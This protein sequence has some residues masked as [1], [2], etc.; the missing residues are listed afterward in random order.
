MMP[1]WSFSSLTK[2]ETCPRQYQL[3]KVTKQVIEPP[4]E[5]T[6]W[7]QE[8]HKALE[9]RVRDGTPLTGKYETYEPIAGKISSITGTKFC[10]DEFAFRRDMTRCEFDDPEAWCRGIID[11]WVLNGNKAVAYDYKT[12]KV[13]PNLDQLRLF[14]AFIMQAYPEV[15]VVSTGFLWLAHN[16][17]TVETFTRQQLPEIWED[18][19]QRSLRLQASFDNDRWVPKPSG[20]CNGW[21]SAGKTL[22][23]FWSPKRNKN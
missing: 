9:D 3:V 13:K 4:T 19:M 23:E 7:G 10:E 22:C 16:K 1:P 8:V 5:Y 2:Y 20:L 11:V 21:C 18:F 6:I 14:A 12:G 15:E 17:V